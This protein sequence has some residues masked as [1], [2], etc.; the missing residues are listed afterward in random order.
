MR[1]DE[2]L[3]RAVARGDRIAFHEL[4][5]RHAERVFRFAV[6]LLRAPHLAEEVLQETMVAVWKTA[7]RFKGAS[8]VTTWILGIAKNQAYGLLR[9]EKRGE[10]TP[11]DAVIERD[12][13][14]IAELCVRVEDAVA[15]LPPHL[16]EVLHLVFHEEMTLGE[17]ADVLGIPEGTVKSRMF[18][19]RKAL[20]KVLT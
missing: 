10:R 11:D 16:R 8:K 14:E 17:A 13:S 15:T 7:D 5:E 18:H 4:Y 2:A 9:R 19:A 20:A 12:P 1:T 6:S 3:L